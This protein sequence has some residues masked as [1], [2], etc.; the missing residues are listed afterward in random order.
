MADQTFHVVA[1]AYMVFDAK[2]FL[3]KIN[4]TGQEEHWVP[5]GGH[6]RQQSSPQSSTLHHPH[7][8]VGKKIAV[9]QQQFQLFQYGG[10]NLVDMYQAISPSKSSVHLNIAYFGMFLEKPM[11]DNPGV[12]VG[13]FDGDGLGGLKE[14]G[15]LDDKVWEFSRK[16]L[17]LYQE[18]GVTN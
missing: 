16:A 15:G 12:P 18:L 11:M 8:F 1:Q 13:L 3:I 9:Y 5:I 2:V 4:P 10:L 17:R 14:R 6:I 7:H